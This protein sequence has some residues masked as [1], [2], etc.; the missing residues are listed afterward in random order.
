MR[1]IESAVRPNVVVP[2]VLSWAAL[3]MPLTV[4]FPVGSTQ[5]LSVTARE[6]PDATSRLPLSTMRVLAAAPGAVT[7]AAW[8][9]ELTT[10]PV[11]ASGT[12]AGVQLLAVVQALEV[13]FLNSAVA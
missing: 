6:P 2:T 1:G 10:A 8:V 11:E 3:R 12:P 7:Q 13:A 5:A 9:G 4:S